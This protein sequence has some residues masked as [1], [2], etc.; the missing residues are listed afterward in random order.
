MP[1]HLRGAIRRLF[2]LLLLAFACELHAE[3]SSSDSHNNEKSSPW[4]AAP[5]ISSDPK[6]GTSLGALGAYLHDF[7]EESPVS[8]FGLGAIYSNTDSYGGGLFAQTYF[9]KDT[10]RLTAFAGGGKIR[11]D[12][13]DFLGSGLPVQTTD[14]LHIFGARYYHL[15]S[16]SNWY[17]GPQ[18]IST[19]YAIYGGD[20]FSKAVL[21]L[22]GLTGFDSN[23]IGLAILYDSLD[24]QN[25][26][27]KGQQLTLHNIAYRKTFGGDVSFDSYQ[28]DYQ[29]YFT[30][31]GNFVLGFHT[32]GRWT[33][34]A[35]TSGYSSINMRGYVRG[36]NLAENMIMFEFDERIPFTRR[37]GG[38]LFTGVTCLYGTGKKC[39]DSSNLFP[40]IGGG[41]TFVIKPEDKIIMR[42]EYAKGKGDNSGFYLTFG[43]PF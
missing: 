20:I 15:L 12:Y 29:K 34:N 9:D 26:P 16:N 14:D 37:W 2:Y 43:Q 39:S 3:A 21:E 22:T 5:L 6:V 23:G 17:I 4:L 27:A 31:N 1:N 18:A 24:N 25:S 35:P 28:A 36:Q 19:N 13:S 40:M 10:Q 41:I 32:A 8:M 30:H 33:N 7:D 38:T 42:A 11:N